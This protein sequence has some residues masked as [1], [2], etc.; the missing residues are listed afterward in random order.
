MLFFNTFLGLVALI[1][2]GLI[3]ATIT[4]L[5]MHL[6]VPRNWFGIGYDVGR[7][8]KKKPKR[9]PPENLDAFLQ[10]KDFGFM[11]RRPIGWWKKEV[12]KNDT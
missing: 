2:S 12:D 4:F 6:G 3:G 1:I 8:I 7:G 10:G 9:I 5:L 11:N